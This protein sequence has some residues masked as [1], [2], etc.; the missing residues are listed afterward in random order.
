MQAKKINCVF[1][2]L[3]G[4]SSSSGLPSIFVRFQGCN[5]RCSY[6]D[7]V[8]AQKFDAVDTGYMCTDIVAQIQ[9]FLEKGIH[10]IILTGGEPL[11]QLSKYDLLHLYADISNAAKGSIITIQV[12]TNGS[13]PLPYRDDIT[14]IRYVM[15]YKLPLS[16]MEGSMDLDNFKKLKEYDELKFVVSGKEDVERA[17]DIL[18][19]YPIKCRYIWFS[20][21]YGDTQLAQYVWN[22][23]IECQIPNVRMQLQLHKIVFGDTTMEV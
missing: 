21:V 14:R 8:R 18:H 11:A 13:Y 9:P 20:P 6:C 5:L 23:I 1:A 2:S 19:T 16:E 22:A 7:T 4:E 17:F 15:D 3:S 12:E 10:N